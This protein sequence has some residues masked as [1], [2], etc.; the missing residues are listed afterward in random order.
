[1]NDIEKQVLSKITPTQKYR[2]QI[3]QVVEEINSILEENIKEKKL[4]VSIELVG[5]IAKD[6]Y[7]MNNMDID[8]FIC[9][10][11]NYA[12][13]EIAD[14]TLK[15]GKSFLEKTE[16][17][18]AEHPYLRGY[19]KN[20][21]TELV[22]CYRIEKASQKLS[23]VDRT[24]LHTRYIK[25]NIKTS[26]KQEVRLFKQFLKGINCYGAEAQIEGFSG[27]L[28]EIIILYYETF[29]NTIKN[30]SQWEKQVALS[31]KKGKHS[32]FDTPLVF[33]DP[34]DADRNVASAL[35][36]EKFILFIKACKEFLKK[37]SIKFFFPKPL[38]AWSVEKIKKT[39]NK[40]DCK[41]ICVTFK[42][43]DIIDENLY[44]QVRKTV[45]SVRIALKRYGFTVLDAT[46]H[47]HEKDVYIFVKIE[48]QS[49][50]ETMIHM[51]PPV[52]KQ[53][54][55]EDFLN[56]WENNSLVIKRPYQDNN[57]WYVE[58]KRQYTDAQVFLK[59][60]FKNLSRG[61]HIDKNVDIRYKVLEQKQLFTESLRF[62]WTDYLDDKYSWEW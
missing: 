25:E 53:K 5:S 32:A 62:F 36:E 11:T 27:Y 46:Y 19:Y 42:K 18:Y 33:I 9:F 50:A 43:P 37:P 39:I 61:K 58:I 34:V 40:Q 59:D 15:I 47:V 12:K 45:K 3:K 6:T 55:S 13:K 35:S 38:K 29:E 49:L 21:Y 1:M 14:E 48:K 8:F 10:P 20:F 56:K 7:L 54:N 23:A 26:Q 31:M 22:P 57:R 28:C 52:K 16:E 44:P 17:S 41:Y 24:P 30:A 60:E 51:G 4:P 2:D